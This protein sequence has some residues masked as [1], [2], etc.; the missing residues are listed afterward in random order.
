MGGGTLKVQYWGVCPLCGTLSQ[1]FGFYRV[2]MMLQGLF[3]STENPR[4]Q[5]GRQTG[6]SSALTCPDSFVTLK[7][8]DHLVK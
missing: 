7:K 6:F 3:F 8:A 2:P 4:G 5:Q 1:D